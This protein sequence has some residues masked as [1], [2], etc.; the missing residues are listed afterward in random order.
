[1]NVKSARPTFKRP[2]KDKRRARPAKTKIQ[3]AEWKITNE[4][5]DEALEYTFPASDALSIVQTVRSN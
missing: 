4:R 2:N 3:V 5:L 1:M